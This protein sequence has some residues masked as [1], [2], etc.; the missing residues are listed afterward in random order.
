MLCSNVLRVCAQHWNASIWAVSYA[1][2]GVLPATGHAFCRMHHWE[3]EEYH[4]MSPAIKNLFRANGQAWALF[5][6]QYMPE[7]W[8]CAPQVPLSGGQHVLPSA[9]PAA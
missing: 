5:V 3:G 1:C 4:L 7:L 8:L 6:I 9:I 2:K